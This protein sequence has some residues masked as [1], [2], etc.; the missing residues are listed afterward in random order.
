MKTCRFRQILP[1]F[2][3]SGD[4]CTHMDAAGLSQL[5]HGLHGFHRNTLG[6]AQVLDRP[7]H[8][9][10][11]IPGNHDPCGLIPGN[12]LLG[13]LHT[14]YNRRT[15][16]Y[17]CEKHF[18]PPKDILPSVTLWYCNITD[19]GCQYFFGIF[20]CFSPHFMRFFL[21]TVPSV[22]FS[23]NRG[24][25]PRFPDTGTAVK[26]ESFLVFAVNSTKKPV[27]FIQKFTIFLQIKKGL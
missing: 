24:K 15:V 6:F 27:N 19:T 4:G 8:V 17:V 10:I 2:E 3:H 11:R 22:S 20:F 23:V 14:D 18:T 9:F 25:N 21:Y 1:G 12:G 7:R 5:S 26:Q 13:L 16:L